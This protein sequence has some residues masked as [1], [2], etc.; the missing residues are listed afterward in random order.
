MIDM[1]LPAPE[2][3]PICLTV[4]RSSRLNVGA[5]PRLRNVSGG[6]SQ[7]GAAMPRIAASATI[8][9]RTIA[10]APGAGGSVGR[11]GR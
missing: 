3:R 11:A 4:R 7:R 10:I 5:N 2:W 6:R 8:G 1:E 9:R